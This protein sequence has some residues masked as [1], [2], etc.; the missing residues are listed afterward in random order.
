MQRLSV[1]GALSG[2]QQVLNDASLDD[3]LND[4]SPALKHTPDLKR[5]NIL[6]GA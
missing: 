1:R 5:C 3:H 2:E 4:P 6:G